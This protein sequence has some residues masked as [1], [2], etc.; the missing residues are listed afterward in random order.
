MRW[1]AATWN[2]AAMADTQATGNRSMRRHPC[3]PV[4]LDHALAFAVPAVP[5][6]GKLAVLDAARTRHTALPQPAQLLRLPLDLRPK[7]L[8]FLSSQ[9]VLDILSVRS[10]A[11]SGCSVNLRHYHLPLCLSAFTTTH[12]NHL[13]RFVLSTVRFDRP[14]LHRNVGQVLDFER[15]GQSGVPVLTN[16]L[17]DECLVPFEQ[18]RG[19]P[20]GKPLAIHPPFEEFRAVFHV[21][22]SIRTDC[23]FCQVRIRRFS[24]IFRTI[25]QV[26]LW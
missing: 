3:H 25:R 1:I 19:F 13:R 9:V 15:I 8:D 10:V 20:L 17:R 26:L 14:R 2:I 11:R 18:F 23:P 5:S 7:P 21:P 12:R 6:H 16:Q 22:H 24:K 4:R